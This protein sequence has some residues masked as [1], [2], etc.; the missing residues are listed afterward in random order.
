MR[1]RIE[2]TVFV[3]PA[4]R[5]RVTTIYHESVRRA[6]IMLAHQEAQDEHTARVEVWEI[7]GRE[8]LGT[9]RGTVPGTSPG[10]AGRRILLYDL[11]PEFPG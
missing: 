7:P 6:A 4:A 8:G 5:T 9:L 11:T 3:G 10:V 1:Y 2:V